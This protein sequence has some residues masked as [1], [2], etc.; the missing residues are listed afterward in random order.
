MTNHNEYEHSKINIVNCLLFGVMF[1]Y[2]SVKSL[3]SIPLSFISHAIDFHTYFSV[4]GSIVYVILAKV[5]ILIKA[6]KNTQICFSFFF[7][8]HAFLFS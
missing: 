1:R 4:F 6:H 8:Y 3:F 7:C 2:L 5:V